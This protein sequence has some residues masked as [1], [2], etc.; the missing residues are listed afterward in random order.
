MRTL[1]ALLLLAN[2]GFLAL[3]QGWLQPYVGLSTHHEREPQR[4]AAQIDPRI[5]ARACGRS[6]RVGAGTANCICGPALSALEQIEAPEA[7]PGPGRCRHRRHGSGSRPRRLAIR[8][9]RSS[10]CASQHPDA[11][12][13]QQLQES[14]AATPGG[15]PG[16][17]A[18]RR[19]EAQRRG[20]ARAAPA[21]VSAAVASASS[22]KPPKAPPP[23]L[24]R[25][26]LHRS[27]GGPAGPAPARH[28]RRRCRSPRPAAPGSTR[29]LA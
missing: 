15:Q 17:P 10:G 25:R 11:A 4:L 21:S 3:A 29:P 18:P 22:Q 9:S 2:L 8:A 16:A 12:L 13:R 6:G 24:V 1:V 14:V 7:A 27:T 26:D 28:R 23:L 5:G 20:A 19:A